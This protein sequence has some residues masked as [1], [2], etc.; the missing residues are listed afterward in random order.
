VPVE[1]KLPVTVVSFV[2]RVRAQECSQRHL[3]AKLKKL[4]IKFAVMQAST[5]ESRISFKD[6][7]QLSFEGLAL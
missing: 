5:R 6:P 7:R 3:A 4:W 1:I 2:L